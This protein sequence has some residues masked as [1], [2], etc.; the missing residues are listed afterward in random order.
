MGTTLVSAAGS[1]LAA[2]DELGRRAHALRSAV[3]GRI[4]DAQRSGVPDSGL[5]LFAEGLPA[6]LSRLPMLESA[7][8]RVVHNLQQVIPFDPLRRERELNLRTRI[9]KINGHLIVAPSEHLSLVAACHP[10]TWVAPVRI[11]GLAVDERLALFPGPPSPQGLPTAWLS[12]DRNLIA[13]FCGIWED[14][15]RLAVPINDMPGVVRL[16]ER[17]LDVAALLSRGAKDATSARLLGVSL[18][19][20]TSDIGKL[21]D[22]FGVATRWEAGMA[23]G[24]ACPPGLT[25]RMGS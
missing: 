18:R 11:A 12:T 20:V 23:I 7:T 15:K 10:D 8:K 2:A 14:V 21:M 16:T 22:A 6:I 5:R 1:D 4:L 13:E 19:T 17:Q 25:G 3:I 24:R 9:R